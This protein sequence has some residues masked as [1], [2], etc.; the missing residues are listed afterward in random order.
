MG[1]GS[2][3][4]SAGTGLVGAGVA[5]GVLV[6]DCVINGS[7]RGLPGGTAGYGLLRRSGTDV[8]VVDGS[9]ALAVC[10]PAD[11]ITPRLHTCLGQQFQY[12]A[13]VRVSSTGVTSIAVEPIT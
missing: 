5:D 13:H 4:K 9:A 1:Q 6:I 7:V 12:S 3:S 8:V 10:D 2:S 11:P